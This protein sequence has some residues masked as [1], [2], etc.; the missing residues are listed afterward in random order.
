MVKKIKPTLPAGTNVPRHIAIIPDGNRRWARGRGVPTFEGHLRGFDIAPDIFRAAREMGVHTITAWAF[1]TENWNR[2]KAEINYLM[3]LYEKFIDRNLADAK[4]DKVR[5]YHLGRKDRIPN[6]LRKKIENAEKETENNQ[7]HVLNVALDYGGH[8]ELLRAMKRASDAVERRE[9]KFENLQQEVGKYNGKYP[10]Y[11]FKNYLDTQGQTNPYPD[12][13]IRTSGEQRVSG[14]MSWQLAYAEYYWE[15]DHF[16]DFTPEKLKKAIL[17]FS[18][19][20]RRFG[21]VDGVVSRLSYDSRKA[22]QY[23]VGWWWAHNER[24]VEKMRRNFLSWV[25]ELYGVGKNDAKRMMEFLSEAVSRGHDR[26][27]WDRAVAQM[28]GFYRLVKKSMRTDFEPSRAAELEVDWWRVHDELEDSVDKEP[29]EQAFIELYGEIFQQ[30]ALQL[31]QA[32]H[33][34]AMAT[35]EHD[36]AEKEGVTLDEMEKHWGKARDYLEKFYSALRELVS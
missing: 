4:K 19:R 17:D 1:S 8:D 22:A 9:V 30:S 7:K 29:L 13:I 21:G 35:F 34:R 25:K 33:W 2:S 15:K 16:P 5:I 14:F 11:L 31:Q 20:R 12:L 23:E 18:H 36:L 27:D 32:A 3:K 28:T 10:Y 26:R 24:D 6:S